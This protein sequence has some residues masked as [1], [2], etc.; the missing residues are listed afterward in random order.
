MSRTPTAAFALS[1]LFACSSKGPA[2]AEGS[3][4]W[5]EDSGVAG[6]GGS[7]DDGGGWDEDDEDEDDEGDEDNAAFFWGELRTDGS[8]ALVGYF[9]AEEGSVR[10][11][12]DYAI[13][14]IAVATDCDAC[15]AAYTLEVGEAALFEGT[16]AACAASAYGGLAGASV[17][18]GWA[19]EDLYLRDAGAW[20]AAPDAWVEEEDGWTLFQLS[21][22]APEADDGEDD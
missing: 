10:C 15:D 12:L 8:E 21:D 11:D 16:E 5:W 17:G 13:E 9:A 4:N 2:G 19:G 6:A 1:L 18:I 14:A 7:G 22:G 20:R 3:G